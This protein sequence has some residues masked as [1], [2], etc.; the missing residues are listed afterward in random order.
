MVFFY[1]FGEWVSGKWR[2]KMFTINTTFIDG[3]KRF[4]K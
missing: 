1:G 4:E 3:E 2:L